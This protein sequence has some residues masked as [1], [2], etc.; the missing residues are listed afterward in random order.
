M[1]WPRIKQRFVWINR[2]STNYRIKD[3]AIWD[4]S[5]TWESLLFLVFNMRTKLQFRK[6]HCVCWGE[7]RLAPK[8]SGQVV[9]ENTQQD[10]IWIRKIPWRRDRLPTLVFLS[11]PGGSD[12]KES[13]CNAGYLGSIPLGKVPWRRAWQLTPVFLPG[14]TPWIEEPGRLQSMWSQSWTGL[15]G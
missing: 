6:K 13:T 3:R 1:N 2:R 9:V 14:E 11:F 10:F 15:K 4:L 12:S 8:S 5:L 7:Q